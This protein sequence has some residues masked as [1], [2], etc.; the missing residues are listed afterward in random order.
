[1]AESFRARLRGQ[2]TLVGSIV[3][4]AS[5]AVAEI[6]A[7]V[8]FDWLFIDGEHGALDIGDLQGMIQA[9]AE[10]CACVVR[11]PAPDE[12]MI[13]RV[14]DLG[15]DGIIAP[16]VNS[17]EQAESVVRAARYAPEGMRGVGFR[18]P[19]PLSYNL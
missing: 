13:K 11:I 3:S 5:P 12:T 14:L 4:L 17:A 1:M 6:M 15:A 16:Q 2:E 19:G 10:R 8:G 7:E 18:R 9:V